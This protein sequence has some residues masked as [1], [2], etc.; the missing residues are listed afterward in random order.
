MRLV[1]RIDPIFEGS[2]LLVLKRSNGGLRELPVSQVI[3]PRSRN[4]FHSEAPIPR[5]RTYIGVLL[6]RLGSPSLLKRKLSVHNGTL[7]PRVIDLYS[8]VASVLAVPMPDG[9]GVE[10]P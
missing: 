2:G 9:E 4:R 8:L 3:N 6:A 1:D 5:G 7:Y 10:E